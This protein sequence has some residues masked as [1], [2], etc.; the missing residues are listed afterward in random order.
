MNEQQLQDLLSALSLYTSFFFL[1]IVLCFASFVAV[2]FSLIHNIKNRKNLQGNREFVSEIIQTQEAERNRISRELHDTISQNI[3]TLLLKEK[4]LSAILSD[5]DSKSDEI[6]FKIEKIIDLEKQNQKQLRTIIQNFAVPAVGNIPFKTVINDLCE[7]FKEQSGIECS[8]FVSPEVALDDFSKEQKHHIL[9]I[10]QEA[11]NNAQT[12]AKASET[13]I[14]IRKVSRNGNDRRSEPVS[15]QN[16]QAGEDFICIMIFD[17]GQGFA[18]TAQIESGLY[19]QD[20]FGMSG[21]EMRAKLLGGSLVVQS[22]A[23]AG[24]EVRLEIPVKS[25]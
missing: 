21:M 13:S 20:H 5:S 14:V 12:H 8:F 6:Q 7:R 22:T 9:R 19:S 11:L 4:E 25:V 24:T 17:D 1:L 15:E 16:L 18:G 23:E 10:I 3:K 2:L